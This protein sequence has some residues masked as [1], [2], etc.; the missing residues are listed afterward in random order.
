[1]THR[2]SDILLATSNPHKLEEVSAMFQGVG[3]TVLGL[4]SLS[5][6]PTEPVE[7]AD[8]FEDNARLKAIGYA[9]ATGRV[10]LADDSGLEVDA[11]GGAPGVH[12]ARYAGTGDSRVQRDAANNAK[13][14]N[15]LEGVPDDQRSARFVCCLC[16]AQPDGTIALESRGTFDGRI[17]HG[18]VGD[19]GFGYDPLLILPEGLTSAELSPEQKNKRSHRGVAIAAL[20]EQLRACCES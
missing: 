8:T 16:M 11:L 13:L 18:L 2:I 19:N 10:C 17:G 14:L 7:D 12:S 4:D 1:M 6:I 5:E 9:A 15:S 3:I 20:I